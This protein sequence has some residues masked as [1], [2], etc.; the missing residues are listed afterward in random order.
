[1]TITINEDNNSKSTRSSSLSGQTLLYFFS[2]LWQ[3][4]DCVR[5]LFWVYLEFVQI[6]FCKE[7]KYQL[8][9]TCQNII[10]L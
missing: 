5:P 2:V 1:M 7:I 3:I 10:E 9:K 8:F 4:G 6:C